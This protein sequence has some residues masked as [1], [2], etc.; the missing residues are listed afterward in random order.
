MRLLLVACVLGSCLSLPTLLSK[1]AWVQ[2]NLS[3]N[4]NEPIIIELDGEVA[5]VTTAN[6]LKLVESGMYE[7][8]V[9]H[10][11]IPGFVAQGGDPTQTH[12]ASKRHSEPSTTI[13]LEVR[14]MEQQEIHYSSPL[15]SGE[16]PVL[17]H[18]IGS[19]AMARTND[20]NSASAQFYFVT[21]PEQ[22]VQHLNGGYVVFGKVV[23]GLDVI[24]K[25]KQGDYVMASHILEP[26]KL[27]YGTKNL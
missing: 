17:K 25:I 13:P 7:D 4:S 26:E 11:V 27:K 9:F 2:L 24:M 15:P 3:T 1:K 6:F 19:V 5:P 14:S 10:R 18:E 16:H 21:G 12:D 22:N 20:P 23:Q 8:T